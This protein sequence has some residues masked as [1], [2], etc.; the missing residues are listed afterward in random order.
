MCVGNTQVREPREERYTLA[1]VIRSD[2]GLVREQRI[3]HERGALPQFLERCERGSSVAVETV[4]NWYWIVDEPTPVIQLVLTLRGVG[5]TPAAGIAL[6]VGDVTR[7]CDGREA[8]RRQDVAPRSSRFIIGLGAIL[9]GHSC[10]RCVDHPPLAR[11][12]P[13]SAA[14]A[15]PWQSGVPERRLNGTT[16]LLPMDRTRML[17]AI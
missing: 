12:G 13:L 16:Q 8:G 5:L 11:E 14:G 6:E 1:L 3:P 2:G 15:G 4:G 17:G 9:L 10:H 7:V